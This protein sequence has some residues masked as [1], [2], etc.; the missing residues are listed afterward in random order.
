[1][2]GGRVNHRT[3]L[4][5]GDHLS[6]LPK[7]AEREMLTA[8]TARREALMEKLMEKTLE[9]K[10]LC[11]EEAVS[12]VKHVALRIHITEVNERTVLDKVFVISRIIN[13]T[14]I[15][16]KHESYNCFIIH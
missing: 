7:A 12:S 15:I 1:M 11:I 16:T 10:K 13:T 2:N 4:S 5:S 9:L 8:L 14:H 6:S 3:I